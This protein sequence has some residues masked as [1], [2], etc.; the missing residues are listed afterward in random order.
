MVLSPKTGTWVGCDV[1]PALSLESFGLKIV[2]YDLRPETGQKPRN[3]RPKREKGKKEPRTEATVSPQS[4]K[5]P[6]TTTQPERDNA[7]QATPDA[8]NAMPQRKGR[9][10]EAKPIRQ[11]RC[12][13][14]ELKFNIEPVDD[15][16]PK[17]GGANL[18]SRIKPQHKPVKLKIKKVKKGKPKE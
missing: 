8:L 12:D 15:K 4:E 1:K 14:C 17:C 13:D 7:P 2:Y 11:W 16:C 6:A 10:P 5:P 3:R 18:S 9:K